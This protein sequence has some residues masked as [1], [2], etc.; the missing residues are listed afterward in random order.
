MKRG[1]L[2]ILLLAL[3]LD[4]IG[5]SRSIAFARAE[6]SN[7]TARQ[8][9]QRRPN[10]VLIFPDNSVGGEVEGVRQRAGRTDP[11][12]DRVRAEWIRLTNFSIKFSCTVSRAALLTGGY[13][14]RTGAVQNSG[15]TQWEIF[16]A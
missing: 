3:L 14:V 4:L 16:P 1:L 11:N 5:G 6:V 13:A 7:N 9:Q 2:T 8:T 12:I 10:I 15:I